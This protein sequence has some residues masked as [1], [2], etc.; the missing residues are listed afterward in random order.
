MRVE[1]V[2][3]GSELLLGQIADTN[4][5]WL[6]EQLAAA[7]ISSHFHTHVGDNHE[8]IV[9]ALRTAL[10]RSD[11][12]IVCGGLGPT[13]DDIT[14]A[15]LAE[16]MNVPL[17]RDD[18]IVDTI[19]AM[20]ASRGRAMPDNNMLQADV[21]RGARVIAQTRGTAP[22]LICP[23]GLK[24]AYALPGVPYEMTDMFERAVLPDLRE[25]AAARGERGV[26]ASRVLKT[27][28]SS[29]S[30]LAEAVADRFVALHGGPVTIAFLASGI[31]G[32]K[33]RL[34]ARGDDAD[35]VEVL[36]AEEEDRVRAAIG[37]RLGDIVFGVDD[38]TMED[39]VARRLVERGLTLA[40]AESL[41]GGLIASR[42]VNVVGASTW[43]V[44]GVV[45]YMSSVKFDLLH[46][47]EGPVVSAEA[48][49]AMAAGVAKRLGADVGLS[50]TGV[51]GPDPQDGQ[52][53]GTVVV[54]VSA[55]GELEHADLRLPG[56]RPRVRAYAAISALDVLR[57]RLDRDGG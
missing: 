3:V 49:E 15:A 45:S 7:G 44:G 13:Q 53:P 20:F 23:L 55:R 1:V 32:I 25:R 29:E 43:F 36:L 5:Q 4:S 37:G 24:V 18:D 41:T 11:A 26:I 2:A 16:V 42:L 40:V 31:E 9:L 12:V 19:R 34:T 50:V 52:P 10:A 39:A 51:A 33:V 6:G 28:G 30:A 56:D 47:P 22:G 48:A 8:R 14:R 38:E 21:P 35:G 17:E 57:R 27:W 54:G 46:V